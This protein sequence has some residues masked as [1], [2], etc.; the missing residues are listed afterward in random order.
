MTNS[1]SHILAYNIAMHLSRG[2]KD[3]FFAVHT[4]RPGDGQRWEDAIPTY[5]NAINI[6][7]PLMLW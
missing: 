4:L 1:V 2:H 3:I 7:C 5:T 6:E